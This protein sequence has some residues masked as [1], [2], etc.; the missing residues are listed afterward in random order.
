MR[1]SK[2]LIFIFFLAVFLISPIVIYGTE[3]NW[4]SSPLTR[5]SL[6]GDSEFHDLIA[7]V[8]GWGIGLGGLLTFIMFVIAGIEWMTSGGNPNK[9]AKAK[10]RITSTLLGLSLLLSSW[11]ILNTINPQLTVLTPLPSLWDDAMYEDEELLY[12][13]KD[14]P[15]EFVVFYEKSD[16]SGATSGPIY[17]QEQGYTNVNLL[18]DYQSGR[19]FRQITEEEKEMLEKFGS[20]FFRR[21]EIYENDYIEP[22]PCII[23]IYEE[24]KEGLFKKNACGKIIGTIT[25]PNKNFA[26]TLFGEVEKKITCFV[27]EDV[28]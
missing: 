22:G 17:P 27:V 5:V 14:L 19:A 4:P 13:E 24:K 9:Q 21:R 3:I 7:Y 12:D 18:M 15:C 16:F 11:L 25:F 26:H 1:L 28:N 20:D 23:T 10:A 8:Y 6:S 2:K